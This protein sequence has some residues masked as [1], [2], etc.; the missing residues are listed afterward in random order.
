MAAKKVESGN[1]SGARR[2]VYTVLLGGYENFNDEIE[3]FQENIEFICLTDNPDLR[4]GKWKIELVK[5]AFPGDPIR[6]QRLLK[7]EG[8]PILES[9][10]ELVYIDNSVTITGPVEPIFNEW[11]EDTDI[12]FPLHSF[13][14]T[15][16]D[17]FDAVL[18]LERDAHERV[19]EQLFHYNASNPEIFAS[20]PLWTGLFARKNNVAVQQFCRLWFLHVARYSRRDQLSLPFVLAYSGKNLQVK[21]IALDNHRSD[22]HQWLWTDVQEGRP[23][24]LSHAN[25]EGTLPL[26]AEVTRLR[27]ELARE[28][29]KSNLLMNQVSQL[30]L[31]LEQLRQHIEA[32]YA[33]L[34]WRITAPLRKLRT[35][36]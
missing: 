20:Q 14:Q 27:N 16:I 7:L 35:R 19:S 11:L 18:R 8:H 21:T 34:S 1:S 13:H 26:M 25:Y 15:V 30:E 28:R 29:E 6:S 4:S 23:K 3:L 22:F 31:G 12:C 24:N 36:Q 9:F 33:T 17:E 32:V 10:D 5:P 2:A